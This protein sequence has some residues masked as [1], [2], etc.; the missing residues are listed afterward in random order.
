MSKDGYWFRFRKRLEKLLIGLLVFEGGGGSSSSRLLTLL[1]L[2]WGRSRLIDGEAGPGAGAPV[3]DAHHDASCQLTT[4]LTPSRRHRRHP[5]SNFGSGKLT[6][7]L[8]AAG[9]GLRN[10]LSLNTSHWDNKL[11]NI[12][13]NWHTGGNNEMK[14]RSASS[15]LSC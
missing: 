14:L 4:V 8:H 1:C 12:N 6:D 7:S 10:S 13:D 11:S 5:A 15:M 3:G 9:L 2:G